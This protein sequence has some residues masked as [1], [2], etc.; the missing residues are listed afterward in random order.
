MYFAFICLTKT[1]AMR[2]Y[3]AIHMFCLLFL[4]ISVSAFAQSVIVSGNIRD[5]TNKEF[6]PAVSVTIKGSPG[7]TFTDDHGNFKLTTIQNF[8]FVLVISSI[9]FETREI[10]VSNSSPIQI[11]MKPSSSLGQEIVVSASR[12]PQ[13]ILESPV[14]IERVSAANIRSSPSSSYYDV[15]TNLKG[16]DMT[17]SSLTF[18]TPS[19]RGFNTSGNERLNQLVD[20]MDNQAPGLNFSVG[21]VIGLTELD[22]DN[23]ELLPGASSALYGSGGMNGTI[24]ITSKNPFKYQ[25]VSAE[26]KMGAMHLGKGDEIGASPYYNIALRW[27]QQVCEKF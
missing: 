23:M 18:K 10:T 2:K 15:L 4:F 14:S 13:R 5:L 26:V 19:T 3:L 1:C 22:V 25:G 6:V 24:L 9:G 12:V 7:G 27:G 17:T 20:G 21:S 11:D 16:V 8:P